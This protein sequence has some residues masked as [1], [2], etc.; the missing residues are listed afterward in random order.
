MTLR[1][2]AAPGKSGFEVQEFRPQQRMSSI[3]RLALMPTEDFLQPNGQEAT[4]GIYT[5]RE[6]GLIMLIC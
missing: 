6:K 5:Y 1:P 4:W 3:Q 2:R